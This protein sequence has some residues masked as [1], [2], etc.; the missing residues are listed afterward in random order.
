[1]KLAVLE[2][3][4]SVL[5]WVTVAEEVVTAVMIATT[6]GCLEKVTKVIVWIKYF[7]W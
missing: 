5:M 4:M 1:M 2:R 6:D 7:A 3:E